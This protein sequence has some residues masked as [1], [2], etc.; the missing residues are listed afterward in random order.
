MYSNKPIVY[1]TERR[2]KPDIICRWLEI[3]VIFI[4]FIIMVVLLLLHS[5]Q[6]HK[7]TFFDHLFNVEI[8]ETMNLG[9][10]NIVFYLLIFLFL[11]SL[12]SP[13]LN[14]K[15][16]KRS[17]DRIH[18]SFIFSLIGSFVGIIFYLLYILI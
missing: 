6:P 4:W 2:K 1:R 18:K 9:L 8:K 3:A 13:L 15:R 11:F 10:L 14:F 17:T 16:M 5:A 12:A 7:E